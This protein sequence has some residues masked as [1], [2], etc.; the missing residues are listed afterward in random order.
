MAVKSNSAAQVQPVTAH[1]L[2]PGL[3]TL[4]FGALLGLGS[5]AVHPAVLESTLQISRIE[6]TIAAQLP[7]IDL[8]G[9]TLLALAFAAT[10]CLIGLVAARTIQRNAAPRRNAGL[11]CEPVLVLSDAL[12][13]PAA[14]AAVPARPV[15][16]VQTEEERAVRPDRPASDPRAVLD[17][18]AIDLPPASAESRSPAALPALDE[19]APPAI[20]RTA[21]RPLPWPPAPAGGSAETERTLREALSNLRRLRG[22][23]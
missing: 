10:G 9:R 2:F 15:P 16:A 13:T 8:A 17:I 4:W 22:A 11:D 7:S 3:V 5:L 14:A 6:Q 1:P 20:E 12:H 18:F 19:A 21:P 23:A